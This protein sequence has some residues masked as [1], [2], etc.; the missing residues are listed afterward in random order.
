MIGDV[1]QE[2][3]RQEAAELDVNNK[4]QLKFIKKYIDS[5]V[6]VFFRPKRQAL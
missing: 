1:F 3:K 4:K 5:A 6:R 2:L